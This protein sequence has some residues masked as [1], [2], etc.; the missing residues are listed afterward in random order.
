[1]RRVR[2]PLFPLFRHPL[3]PLTRT[4]RVLLLAALAVWA[5]CLT[6]AWS[7]AFA[8]D[9]Q[10]RPA[11]GPYFQLGSSEPG[12][13]RL[14]LKST[15]VDVRIA[16]VIA[17]V[18]VTQ[19]YR[20]E[21]QRAIDARYVF[22]GSTRAAVHAMQV[23]LAGRTIVAQI[24]E[25]QRARIR[26]ESAKREGKT[27]AL[28]EQHRPNVFEMNVANIL[29]GDDV[30]VELRYTELVPPDGGRYSFVFPTV[31]GPRYHVPAAQGGTTHF[32]ATP[33]LREGEA[34]PSAFDLTV[35]FAAPL[36]VSE[37]RSPSHGI[38]VQG[39]GT[40][41]AQVAIGEAT[42]RNDRDFIL[43]YRL[44]G[45]RTATG[46]MLYQAPGDDGAD[47]GSGEN[48][49]L[50]LV[51]PPKAIAPAQI[52]PREYV[53]VVDISGSMHGQPLATA[54]TLLRNLIGGLRTSDSFNVMLFSGS[55][56]MLN[57]RPVPATRANIE[58]AIAV[59]DQSRGG[60]S[61]EIV[62]ALR[63]IAALPK[64]ADVARSVIVV[65]DGY[66]TVENQ[67]FELVRKNLGNSN[68]FA[69]GIGSSVN[70]HLIEGIARAGQGEPFIVTKP[71]L[72]AA[73]AERLRRMIEAPVLTQLR[74]RF[75]G[76]EVYDVEPASLAALPDVLGGRPVLIHGKWRGEP[77]GQLVLEGEAANGHHS[78]VV[79]V[80]A[81][82]PTASA[83][84][85]L[86]ARTRIQQLSDQEALEGGS[87][88]R[89]A[90]TTLGLRYSL[91]TQYTSFIAIDQVVRS[92]QPAVPV[93]QPLPLPQGVSESAVGA[94]VPSTPEPAAW[95][96][97][98]VVIGLVGTALFRRGTW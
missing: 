77:R 25:K 31:V 75:E 55:S 69:F 95:L 83:L 56:Q 22:P 78:E 87:G 65:T 39:E 14:P 5:F 89:E 85:Q 58:R 15:R 94:A 67:V 88:Q 7:P 74:A 76:L 93:D 48:F 54:K 79:P 52:N 1:M 34:S 42:P 24:D 29:P 11:E 72:A 20:N 9:A 68:V 66:V 63:R 59:I 92:D 3:P 96:S 28:L 37:L 16:G 17:D 23:R 49:F 57:E 62:P 71:E 6:V 4:G 61:T 60:G 8:D 21:G 98:L 90:I 81:P 27:S 51:E 12:V 45:E 19:Q 26:H 70:R 32:P 80:S 30:A 47:G 35:R 33:Q 73:Q 44:A 53:F 84:R 2:G 97:L 50:A 41:T 46:L 86:W 18:T 38:E 64:N 13:D 10:A 43:E 82:D 91:L 40:P 36:P